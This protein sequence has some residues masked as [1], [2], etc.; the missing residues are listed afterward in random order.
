MRTARRHD[1]SMT[2]LPP[3]YRPV[4]HCVAVVTNL[5]VSSSDLTVPDAVQRRPASREQL[6]RGKPREQPMGA[7]SGP[8][9]AL[10]PPPALMKTM[11]KV[12]HRM[13]DR[14]SAGSPSHWRDPGCDVRTSHPCDG[15]GP[16]GLRTRETVPSNTT[17]DVTTC[18]VMTVSCDSDVTPSDVMTVI[19]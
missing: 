18:D 11:M 5:P 8:E 16:P 6:L 7:P 3:P 14:K 10:S 19:L 17:R 1:D 9:P 4:P 2:A 13:T 12:V 15:G